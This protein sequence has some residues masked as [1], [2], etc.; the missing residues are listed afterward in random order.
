MKLY[1]IELIENGFVVHY[2]KLIEEGLV[3]ANNKPI[4]RKVWRERFYKDFQG[5]IDFIAKHQEEGR[6]EQR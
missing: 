3:G 6:S 1:E 5:A 2:T 4:T